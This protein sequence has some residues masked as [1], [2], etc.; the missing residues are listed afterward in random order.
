MNTATERP[1][2]KEPFFTRDS[3]FYKTLFRMLLVVAMQNLVAYSVNMADNI[4]LGVYSQDSLSAAATVN[5]V[6]FVVQQFALSIGNALVAL[7]AQYWG[8]NRPGPV[9]TLTG[10]ALKLGVILSA[11]LVAVCALFPEPLLYL[12][13]DSAAIVAEGTKYLSLLQWTFA[14][15]ILTNV[16]MAALRSVGIVNISFYVSVV[17]LL[18]NV[19]I[20]YTLIFGRFGFPEL[21]ILGAAVG[22]LTARTLEFLI[23]LAYILRVDK[24]LRLFSGGAL[25]RRAPALRRDYAK[26]YLPIMCSQVLWG[27]S[28]PMQTAIL[29]HLSDDAIAANSI[30]TTFYQYL[31]VIVIAMS[32]V[33]AVMIG[34]AIGRGERKRV[35]SD[36]RSIDVAIGCVLAATLFVL[37]G[38]LV[39]L[40]D[41][42][43]EAAEMARSLIAVMS[44]VMI[45]MSYQ[46][47]VS[48]GIIQG[49]G[50]AG[51][52][53]K[54]NLI[55]TWLIVMPL[56]FMA[57]FWWRWPVEAVVLVIQSDQ[58]FKGLP[59]Y[60][61]FRKYQWMKKLTQDG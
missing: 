33:S 19:G 34:S 10:I 46:M 13:T 43:P 5:Q 2:E 61:R 48:F 23:V 30:A 28:V 50:D 9:R 15:F 26:V 38:P 41:L 24:K 7:A 6:F 59:T 27:I 16:L 42:T 12:F 39:S 58:I 45:G 31:K 40:Y 21:G 56:S 57:A 51:F 20:N 35:R 52:T 37:R 22:T 1:I 14:L 32:S 4:M 49:G 44:V 36:A 29:G 11:A 25:L 60:L 47:P 54:M 53:M 17:S 55:S 18:V 3:G 8:Q